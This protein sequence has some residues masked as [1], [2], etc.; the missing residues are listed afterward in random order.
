MYRFADYGL[1]SSKNDCWYW[2]DHVRDSRGRLCALQQLCA[3][4][5]V[6]LEH[7]TLRKWRHYDMVSSVNS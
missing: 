1:E 7:F 6:H 3:S 2:M 5:G 4:Y